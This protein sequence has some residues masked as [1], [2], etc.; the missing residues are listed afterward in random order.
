MPDQRIPLIGAKGFLFLAF[1]NALL[2]QVTTISFVAFE[3]IFWRE[4]I[5][6]I[7][8]EREIFVSMAA[9]VVDQFSRTKG[10]IFERN[11]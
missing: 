1:L 5:L 10:D 6:P 9:D 8:R 3:A 2:F 11:P 7:W 4:V